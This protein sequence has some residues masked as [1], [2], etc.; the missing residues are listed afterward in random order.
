MKRLRECKPDSGFPRLY[1]A[2]LMQNKT[3]V[4]LHTD[5]NLENN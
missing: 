2:K 1:V 4:K 5:A 3:G